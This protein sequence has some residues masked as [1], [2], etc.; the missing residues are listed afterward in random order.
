MA[1]KTAEKKTKKAIST[2]KIP[3]EQ[4]SLPVSFNQ[5]GAMVSLA[6][7]VAEEV[8]ALALSQ[9]NLDQRAELTAKRIELQPEM[10]VAMVGA[11]LIDKK[12]AITEVK[13][14]TPV[15]RNLIEIEQIFIKNLIEEAKQNA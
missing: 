7:F 6:D 2:V 5:E 14:Q 13:S 11:G 4:W 12:R 8:P 3:S 9:L 1:T 10:E 15:G